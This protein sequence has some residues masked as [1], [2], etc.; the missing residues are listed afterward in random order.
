MNV[1]HSH[2]QD[3]VLPLSELSE[4]TNIREPEDSGYRESSQI[5]DPG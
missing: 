5:M 3:N 4:D 1:S 2:S